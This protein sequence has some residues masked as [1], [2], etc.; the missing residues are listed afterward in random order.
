M[1]VSLAFLSPQPGN[2]LLGPWPLEVST[3][4]AGVDRVDFFVDG[5]LAGV[6]RKAPYRVMYDFGTTPAGHEIVAKVFSNGYRTM[7]SVQ[8][9]TASTAGDSIT[10]DLVEVPLRVH[11]AKTLAV[12]DL[13]LRENGREQTLRQVTPDRGP[14]RFVFVVDRSL[15]MNGGRLPAALRAIDGAWQYLRPADRMEVVLFNHNVAKA[16]AVARGERLEQLFGDVPPSGGTSLRDAVSS[17]AG[18]ERS[19]VIV[20]TDGGD[21]NSNASEEEALRAISGT[22]VVVDALVLGGGSRFLGE[23]AKNTGGEVVR[24]RPD[25]LAAELRRLLLDINSRY[26][27]VYQSAGNG[28]GWRAI[29]VTPRRRGVEIVN[30]RKGYFAR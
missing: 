2:Q 16:H 11:A 9:V 5:A 13:R 24:A 26:L 7:E 22:K 8:L 17:A 12:G 29:E 18:G 6:A 27:V 23:A 25:T 20:I 1:T 10:V 30:A 3:T 15:S 28:T 21:R 4:T 19:Y 14:A